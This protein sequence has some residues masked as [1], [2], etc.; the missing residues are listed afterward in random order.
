MTLARRAVRILALAS[1]SLPSA[2]VAHS[3]LFAADSH[4][5]GG[6]EHALIAGS[7][8]LALAV[9]SLSLA[10]SLRKRISIL[11]QLA[12]AISSTLLCLGGIEALEPQHSIPLLAPLVVAAVVAGLRALLVAAR[13]LAW[14]ADFGV[15]H[16]SLPEFL[17]HYTTAATVYR[18]RRA[19]ALRRP[20]APPSFVNVQ[21]A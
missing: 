14:T 2:V 8:A 5:I 21:R 1:F 20:R 10:W 19:H 15:F 7:V 13:D 16:S 12:P 6:P 4:V 11:P 9:G 18:G 17:C 3:L